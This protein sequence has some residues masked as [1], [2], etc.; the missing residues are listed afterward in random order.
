MLYGINSYSDFFD[1]AVGLKHGEVISPML[2]S[3]FVELFLQDDQCCGLSTD[4]ITFILMLFADDL[5]ILGKDRDDLQKSLDRLEYY[6]NEWGLEVNTERTKVVVF[7]KRG[8]F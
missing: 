3:L 1:C 8:G 4:D 5:V 7:R 2:F 6:C